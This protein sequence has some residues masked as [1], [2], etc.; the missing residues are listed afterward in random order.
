LGPIRAGYCAFTALSRLQLP[1]LDPH[2]RDRRG[3]ERD[4]AAS[5]S[6]LHGRHLRDRVV[7]SGCRGSVR[8]TQDPR[9]QLTK[10]LND[11][12]ELLD[13]YKD[14]PEWIPDDLKDDLDEARKVFIRHGQVRPR[15]TGRV[16][17]DPHGQL[18]D[19]GL[20]G[21]QLRLKLTGFRGALGRFRRAGTK[22]LFRRALR[23][24]NVILDG[25]AGIVPGVE[26]VKEFKGSVEAAT[27]DI[28]P[29]T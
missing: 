16:D 3:S 6:P 11:L 8:G 24:A 23:W 7:K 17:D 18:G 27:E 5:G 25:L 20:T 2:R 15:A 22:V 21:D 4:R 28:E 14:H 26:A 10:F 12:Q 19:A 9:E 29:D 13:E 1:L